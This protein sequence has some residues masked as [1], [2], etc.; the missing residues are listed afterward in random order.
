M[1]IHWPYS[2]LNIYSQSCIRLFLLPIIY[3]QNP[4]QTVFVLLYLVTHSV[5]SLQHLP[6]MLL[7][8]FSILC[9]TL[10]TFCN[11]FLIYSATSFYNT[12]S[13]IATS[14]YE[15]CNTFMYAGWQHH[16]NHCN[17]LYGQ[18][19]LLPNCVTL[20]YYTTASTQHKF[21]ISQ[22]TLNVQCRFRFTIS[23][24]CMLFWL[25]LCKWQ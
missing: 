17:I 15:V 6:S 2:V 8:H 13:Q 11:T 23:N 1:K 3:F 9:S 19:V 4:M 12:F 16:S 24:T 20:F 21:C 5:H 10:C 14:F 25:S 18:L 22:Q 7:Q